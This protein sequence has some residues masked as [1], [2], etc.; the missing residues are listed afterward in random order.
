M[1]CFS[2]KKVMLFTYYFFS[3][4]TIISNNPFWWR[5]HKCSGVSRVNA[6]PTMVMSW[7]AMFVVLLNTWYC[8]VKINISIISFPACLCI[9]SPYSKSLHAKNQIFRWLAIFFFIICPLQQWHFL[10]PKAARR[11]PLGN[12]LQGVPEYREKSNQLAHLPL[13]E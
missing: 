5:K 4:A 10:T 13:P 2:T 1:W 3:L 11:K 12:F 8:L 6:S 9:L 7:I